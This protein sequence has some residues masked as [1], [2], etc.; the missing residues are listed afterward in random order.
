MTGFKK[1]ILRG[2]VV[3]LAVGVVIGAAFASVVQVFVK[4]ILTPFIGMFGGVPDMAAWTATA[5]GSVFLIGELINA[6]LSFL[7]I[8]LVVYFCVVVPVNRLMDRM[9]PPAPPSPK[10]RECPFCLS[11]IPAAATR[12]AFCTSEVPEGAAVGASSA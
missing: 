4:G 6:I 7:I 11:K 3:D 1:F 5:N 12:C 2:N 10:T 9:K 8:A